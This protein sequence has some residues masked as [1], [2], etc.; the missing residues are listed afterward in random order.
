MLTGR[1]AAE[2]SSLGGCAGACLCASPL[3]F[4]EPSPGGGTARLEPL[5]QLAAFQALLALA[6]EALWLVL[7]D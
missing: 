1:L 2:A 4:P 3:G 6:A 7:Q 5:A